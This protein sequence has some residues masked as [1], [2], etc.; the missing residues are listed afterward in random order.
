MGTNTQN[1]NY[2]KANN[3]AYDN[4]DTKFPGIYKKI[5][6]D[7]IVEM[8]LDDDLDETLKVDQE[9]NQGSFLLAAMIPTFSIY[10]DH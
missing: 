3:P 8:Y 7:K 10:G 2:K 5:T 6:G 4:L 1:G 9:F